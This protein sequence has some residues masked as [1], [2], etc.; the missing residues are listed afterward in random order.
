MSDQYDIEIDRVLDAIEADARRRHEASVQRARRLGASL[1]A[2]QDRMIGEVR[3]LS[4]LYDEGNRAFVVE[5]L[6]LADRIGQVRRTDAGRY[7]LAPAEVDSLTMP[8]VAT[9]GTNQAK[10]AGRHQ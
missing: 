3:M 9:R 1:Q 2:D 8:R 6:C 5:L 4:R 10:A 7:G